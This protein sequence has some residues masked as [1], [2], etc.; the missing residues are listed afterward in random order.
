MKNIV[1][2]LGSL[3]LKRKTDPAPLRNDSV[4]TSWDGTWKIEFKQPGCA[5]PLITSIPS[6]FLVVEPQ[7]PWCPQALD[8]PELSSTPFWVPLSLKFPHDLNL[9]A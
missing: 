1:L 8:P 6:F 4:N 9:S 5:P 2:A 3:V 7:I